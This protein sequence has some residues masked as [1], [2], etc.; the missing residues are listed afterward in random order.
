MK[1]L[2]RFFNFYINASIHVALAVLA[3]LEVTDFLLN[4]PADNF[5]NTFVFFGTIAAYNFVKYGVEAEKYILVATRYIKKIQVFSIIC[6]LIALY[7]MFF[8][9][10]ETLLFL[11]VMVALTGLYAIPVLPHTKNLRNLGGLKV[12]IVALVWAGTTVVLP[13]IAISKVILWDIIIETI[14]RFLIVLILLIPFEIRDLAYD[15]PDLKTI[16][17]RFGVANTKVFGSFIVVVFFALTFLKESILPLDIIAKGV[18]FILLGFC[19]FITKR[20]QKKYYASFWIESIPIFW[21]VVISIFYY[22][23]NPAF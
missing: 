15:S 17:Q 21:W 6:L 5:L 11:L 13:A 23:F 7:S 2:I 18:L 4:I 19:M 1:L 20:D 16:P 8:L 22:F 9:S 10:K 3:L 12:F 14:Q